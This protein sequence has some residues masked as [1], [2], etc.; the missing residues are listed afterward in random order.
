MAEFSG[1]EGLR[2]DIKTRTP[3]ISDEKQF[4]PANMQE[5]WNLVSEVVKREIIS[6]QVVRQ[7]LIPFCQKPLSETISIKAL[8][9]IKP[10]G[11]S[12]RFIQRFEELRNYLSLPAVPDQYITPDVSNARDYIDPKE[13]LE[14]PIVD[15]A[16]I[17]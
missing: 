15:E 2:P 16:D 3:I 10:V 13:F 4:P 9:T 1:I 11:R 8:E 12:D 17:R 14:S 6:S 7:A 5:K